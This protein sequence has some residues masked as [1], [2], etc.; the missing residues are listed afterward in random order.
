MLS[1]RAKLS[2]QETG[3][4]GW[5]CGYMQTVRKSKDP[6]PGPADPMGGGPASHWTHRGRDQGLD[7]EVL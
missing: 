5:Q 7:R 3:K 1:V 4:S 6:S 2:L